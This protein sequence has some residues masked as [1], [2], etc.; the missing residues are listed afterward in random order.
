[1]IEHFKIGDLV[2]YAAWGDSFVNEWNY[3]NCHRFGIVTGTR[4]GKVDVLWYSPGPSTESLSV[5]PEDLEI[6][7]ESR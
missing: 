7:S 3:E 6:I 4:T 2:Q 1:M 5:D